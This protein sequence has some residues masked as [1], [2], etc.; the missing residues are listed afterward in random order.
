LRFRST[1][2]HRP[3]APSRPRVDDI[4]HAPARVN[5]KLIRR[6]L[7]AQKLADLVVSGASSILGS[8]TYWS[9]DPSLLPALE[10]WPKPRRCRAGAAMLG[11]GLVYPTQKTVPGRPGRWRGPAGLAEL[12][13]ALTQ[14]RKVD[15]MID[16]GRPFAP[17]EFDAEIDRGARRLERHRNRGRRGFAARTS[18]APL[19]PGPLRRK[20]GQPALRVRWDRVFPKSVLNDATT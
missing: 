16:S 6:P 8:T 10:R 15:G 4:A 2:P 7:R 11:G 1:A 20:A 17:Q 13:D 3:Q 18:G 14:I 9:L 19:G 12:H 5:R